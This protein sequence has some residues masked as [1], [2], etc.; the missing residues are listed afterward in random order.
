MGYVTRVLVVAVCLAGTLPGRARAGQAVPS[1][2]PADGRRVAWTL[3][4][5]GLGF[6]A[7]LLA[8]IGLFDDAVNGDRKV[9]T[10]ALLGAAGGGLA[11]NLLTR[12]G[13]PPASGAG[14]P[15]GLWNGMAVGAAAGAVYGLWYVPKQHCKPDINPECPGLLRLG[16]GLPVIAGGAAIGALVDRA[17]VHR[18][19]GPVATPSRPATLIA[20][21]VGPGLVGVVYSRSFD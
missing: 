4:G 6:G 5:G 9:W 12:R 3:I 10:T 11:G 18:T 15:D 19:P 7:G 20:P 16:V 1:S 2:Q 8:G 21:V 17:I 13:T 14:R